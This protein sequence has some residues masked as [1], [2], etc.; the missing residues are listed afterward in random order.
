MQRVYGV[1]DDE[2]FHQM[3]GAVDESKLSRAQ[4]IGEAIIEK[5]R[6]GETGDDLEAM[7][8][9]DEVMK[10][11]DENKQL[12]DEIVHH[13]QLL[14]T[15][16]DEKNDETMKLRDELAMKIDEQ[17]N[18][19]DELGQKITYLN[20]EL[21]MKN[22]ELDKLKQQIKQANSEATERWQDT[23]SLR[24]EGTK[25]K[26]DLEDIRSANQ[27]LKDELIKRQSETDLL[28]KLREELAAA[29]ANRDRLQD[30]LKVRD[31]DITYF[32]SHVAQLTQTIGQLALPPSQEEAKK[33]GWWRFWK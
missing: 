20:D 18:L 6:R 12:N 30:A 22:D 2:I 15:L 29:N 11:R 7:K 8:L 14:T 32:K 9:R 25:L 19:S 26:K 10:L 31:D 23:K 33:K 27:Q 17:K 28:A 21:A 3:G 13:K 5:L 1:I 16:R 4:W 24:A